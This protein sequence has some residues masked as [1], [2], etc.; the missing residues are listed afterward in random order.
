MMLGLARRL[1][2]SALHIGV[3][4][5]VWR[6]SAR[7]TAPQLTAWTCTVQVSLMHRCLRLGQPRSDTEVHSLT[8]HNSDVMFG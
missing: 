3:A 6:R 8:R 7:W 1:S 5:K 4:S 2:S